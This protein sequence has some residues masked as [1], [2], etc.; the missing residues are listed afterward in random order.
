MNEELVR[1]LKQTIRNI[2]DFPQPGILF[3][4]ITPVLQDPELF[5]QTVDFF[6]E[7]YRSMNIEAV[8]AVESRGFIFGG[9]LAYRLGAA[10]VPVRK[11]GKLPWETIQESYELEYGSATLEVHRDA[12]S[13]ARR[14]LIFDDLLATGG[15]AAATARL[16]ERLGGTVVEIAFLIELT[17]LKGREKLQSYSVF[18]LVQF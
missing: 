2:P 12:L 8:A 11:A 5:Q 1:R 18:S 17:D 16:L 9:A 7:R 14:V 3:R 6:L 15:T 13:N 10:F 4:D